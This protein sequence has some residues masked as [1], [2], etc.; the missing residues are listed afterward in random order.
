[1]PS[2]TTKGRPTD[3][4]F[5]QTK[6]EYLKDSAGTV[7]PRVK[8]QHHVLLACDEVRLIR[9]DHGE[10]LQTML[11]V[12]DCRSR[13][14]CVPG[15]LLP[16]FPFVLC[17]QH[18]NQGCADRRDSRAKNLKT[19]YSRARFCRVPPTDGELKK[20]CPVMSARSEGG[21]SFGGELNHARAHA[22]AH[23]ITMFKSS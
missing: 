21:Y 1:V 15:F 22:Y 2:L 9:G 20:G 16:D 4:A 6:F 14:G 5:W 12:S 13:L 18:A 3:R 8:P 19:E 17:C 23:I 7:S 11:H 10:R